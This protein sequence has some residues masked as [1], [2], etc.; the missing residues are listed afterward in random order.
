[1]DPRDVLQSSV[2]TAQVASKQAQDPEGLY[3]DLVEHSHDLL[4]THDLKGRLLSIN[5]APARLLGYEVEEL[6][7][8][9]MRDIVAPEFREQFDLYLSEIERNGHCKGLMAV[10]TRTGEH[11]IWEYNNT[12]RTEGVPSPIVRGIAHDVTEQKRAERALREASELNRQI[13]TDLAEG[14]VLLDRA[15]TCL[16]W[17]RYMEE[18]SGLTRRKVLGLYALDIFPYLKDLGIEDCLKKALNGESISFPD[19]HLG[20]LTGTD[21][22]IAGKL[23][24]F[25]SADGNITGVIV[26]IQDVTDRK[27]TEQ[28]LKR[29]DADLNRAQA[30][31]RIGSWRFDIM[32][33][34]IDF[35]DET[36]RLM[37]VPVSSRLTG[38]AVM[39]VVHADDHA[40]IRAAWAAALEAGHYETECRISTPRGTRWI[41][42]IADIERDR[43][44]RACA[45][46]GTVQDVTERKQAEEALRLSASRFQQFFTTMPEYCYIV[47]PNGEILDVNPAACAALGYERHE[48]VGKT[49]ASL[50]ALESLPKVHAL[51]EKWKQNGKLRS[52][53]VVI[54]TKSGERRTVLLNAGAIRDVDGSILHS[55]SIQVDITERKHADVA[56]RASEE[57]LRVA[58]QGT[59]IKVFNQDR[60]LRYTWVYNPHHGWTEDDY[61]GKTD[62]EIF[63]PEDAGRLTS[64]KKRVLETGQ[65]AREDITITSEGKTY[66][67][68]LTV[69]PML[70]SSGKIAGVT[71]SCMDVTALRETTEDL[72]KAKERLA[73]EKLYLEHEIQTEGHFDEIIGA[74]ESLKSCLKRAATV[75]ATNATVL[76]LGETGTGKELVARA[77]H[78]MSPRS[79]HSFIKMNCAAIPLGL[80]ESELFGHE[81]GAFTGAISRRVGR[82]ELADKGTL[83]LDEVGE[84]PLALQPKLLRVL[85]DR[86]FERLGSVHTLRVDLRLVAATNRNLLN[87]VG[88]NRFRSDLYYRL[89]VFPIELPPLRERREDIP[90]LIEY[91]TRKHARKMNR[92]I[93]SIPQSTIDALVQW[94]WLGNIRELENFIERSVILT[95]GSVLQ[96]PLGE[97]RPS[98]E[99]VGSGSLEAKERELIIRALRESGGILYGPKGA[100]ARL[101]LKRTTLQS[102]L[103]R[104]GIQLKSFRNRR[105]GEPN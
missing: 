104:L 21:R 17:N 18:L 50:Y 85:Q 64:I 58:L 100:A 29:R 101:G 103:Q 1:M 75:A 83:F 99:T 82:L 81:K 33:R 72:R 53:E 36:Y 69:E 92:P 32:E 25:V 60:D 3:R 55:A 77:I 105:P 23:C 102:K 84:L 56:L 67:G 90:M 37:G 48:L 11:R 80:L 65:G 4:C 24:P 44:G 2:H 22:W 57:R 63:R 93:T 74:S 51:F 43:E 78:R 94:Q 45:A 39:A 49:L 54:A 6:L 15:L 20:K 61:L 35:S 73:E 8:T 30:V 14:V 38:E 9:P 68:D 52:E 79:G 87:D 91:F 89:N 34:V 66:Y 76:L 40:Q 88:E 5:P 70:D 31:A 71:C 41:H 13:I 10:M 96:A 95:S 28:A 86:E 12:L 7:Q 19:T 27:K 26:L 98:Y 97:L 16:V 59:P 47:S 46:I 42:S 62:E